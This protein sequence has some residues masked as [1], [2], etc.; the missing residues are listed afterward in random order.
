MRPDFVPLDSQTMAMFV[1]LT[2]LFWIHPVK[3]PLLELLHAFWNF[4]IPIMA[5]CT[6][7]ILMLHGSKCTRT[8]S[9]LIGLSMIMSDLNYQMVVLWTV[10]TFSRHFDLGCFTAIFYASRT[11][12][13][14]VSKLRTE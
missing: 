1:V 9:E 4:F 8:W 3:E 14:S 11:L 7:S 6:L 5:Q 2:V 13:E 10:L 12:Y